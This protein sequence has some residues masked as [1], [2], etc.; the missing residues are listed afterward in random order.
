MVNLY[1]TEFKNKKLNEAMFLMHLWLKVC[2]CLLSDV[3]YMI[4]IAKQSSSNY[5]H[6]IYRK[7]K[8][9]LPCLF[10]VNKWHSKQE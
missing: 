10:L 4:V 7:Y 2:C 8:D 5:Y 6:V 1:F 3:P 9:Y